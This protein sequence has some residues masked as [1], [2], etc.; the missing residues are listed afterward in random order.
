[1]ENTLAMYAEIAQALQSDGIE[2]LVLKGF[3]Q[4]PDYVEDPCFRIQNDIDL[5]CPEKFIDRV[6]DILA[7]LGLE[8]MIGLDKPSIHLPS[9]RRPSNWTWRGNYFDPQMPVAVDLHYGFWN[10]DATRLQVEGLDQFWS[11]RVERQ[12]NGLKFQALHPAD[13]V[14]FA[15]LHAFRH[16]VTTGFTPAHVYEI[17]RFLK[18]HAANDSLWT[19][20][21][22]WHGPGLRKI[23]SICF[24]LAHRW[25]GCPLPEI[26]KVEIESLPANIRLWLG[27]YADSPLA[28]MKR[29]NKDA[30]WLHLCLV[31][32]AKD[33][34]R[35][36]LESLVP[37]RRLPVQVMKQRGK[38]ESVRLLFYSAKRT[39]HHAQ[40][41]PKTL[42]RGAN[43][44]PNFGAER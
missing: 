32:N 25:F 27:K 14:A 29:P 20:W 37:I 12:V 31:E 4:W 2:H 10:G 23:E 11:R 28:S 16:M 8:R 34:R 19:K 44:W 9:M 43:S 3:S 41:I 22:E 24:S 30:L 42:W 26:A 38:S 35:V 33:R 40:M 7:S 39:W 5:Y 6:R 13:G 21:R 1:M 18:T 36:F 15:S 17:G